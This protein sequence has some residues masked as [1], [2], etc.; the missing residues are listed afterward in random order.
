MQERSRKNKE[1]RKGRRQFDNQEEEF[2]F[3][4][5]NDQPPDLSRFSIR[6][7]RKKS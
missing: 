3:G 7:T 6:K 4:E 1:K 2:K 5:R